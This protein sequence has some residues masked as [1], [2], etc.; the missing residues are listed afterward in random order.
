VS[1]N[2]L[3]LKNVNKV[4]SKIETDE[5][6][7]AISN[8]NME[9]KSGEFVSIVGHSGCG[10]STILRLIAGLLAPT[11]GEILFN[12]KQVTKPTSDI[13]MVFQKAHLFPWLTVYD[14]IA[15]GPRINKKYNQKKVEI[16]NIISTIG[17]FDFKNDYPNQL[18]GGMQQRVA[19]ARALINEPK[20]LLLDEPLGAL[21]AFT[22][23]NMQNEIL[24]LWSKNKNLSI[25]V[26][27]D[28]EEAVYMSTKVYVMASKPGRIKNEINIDLNYPRDRNDMNFIK[29]KNE[30]LDYVKE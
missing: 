4:F 25:M 24:S 30:I 11:S 3:E 26:T 1:N 2:N 12:D 17:L 13:A 23:M 21:D 20:V 8:I 16:E 22:R 19:L 7:E 10:K 9:M 5:L 14:N 18:S 27:H 6:T 28:I 29:Y 15:F